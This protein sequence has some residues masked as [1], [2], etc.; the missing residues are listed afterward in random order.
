MKHIEG[1][2]LQ[3]LELDA[4]FFRSRLK[5]DN[6][7]S[8]LDYVSK[9]CVVEFADDNPRNFQVEDFYDNFEIGVTGFEVRFHIK[10]FLLSFSLHA[11][12]FV[13]VTSS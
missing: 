11:L 10:S 9:A 6:G 1:H 3:V 4:L 12:T 5:I 2:K 7:S 13:P 8:L